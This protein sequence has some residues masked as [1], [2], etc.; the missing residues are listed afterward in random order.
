MFKQGL[1]LLPPHGVAI[2]MTLVDVAGRLCTVRV[3]YAEHLVGDPDTGIIHGGVIT[4][5]LDNASGWAVR[6]HEEWGDDLSMAT[7]DIRIDYMRPA[8]PHKDLMVQAE[9]YKLSKNIAFVRAVA[10][11]DDV[12]DQVATSVAA[13]MLGTPNT[14]RTDVA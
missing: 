3:P 13:F 12:N 9:C 4:A 1:E 5:T 6:C 7:L 14:P 2:G 8:E 11:Q 10:Y